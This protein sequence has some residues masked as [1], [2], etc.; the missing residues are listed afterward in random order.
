MMNQHDKFMLLAYQEAGKAKQRGDWPFGAV[1]VK[2]GRV[3]GAGYTTDKSGGDV[4]EHAELVALREACKNLHTNDLHDCTFYSSNEPCAMC[5][6]GI[7]QAGIG[8]VYIG[9]SRDDLPHLLRPRKLHIEDLAQ[10]SGHEI[11]IHRGILKDQILSLFDD[12]QK[13]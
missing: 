5:A 11:K 1:V 2:E 3:V 4:T 8:N 12:I 10:D 13:E 6:A 7:F 9:V